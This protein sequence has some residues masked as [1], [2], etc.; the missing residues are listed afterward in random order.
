MAKKNKHWQKQLVEMYKRMEERASQP[1]PDPPLLFMVVRVEKLKGRPYWEK[2]AVKQLGLDPVSYW[3]RP[4][5]KPT[6]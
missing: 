4:M 2:D 3:S 1:K 6:K 5:T